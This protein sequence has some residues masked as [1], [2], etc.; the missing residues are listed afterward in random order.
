LNRFLLVKLGKP[1][2]KAVFFHLSGQGFS[3]F[4]FTEPGS[5]DLVGSVV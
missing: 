1:V 3:W 2:S 5:K 4:G